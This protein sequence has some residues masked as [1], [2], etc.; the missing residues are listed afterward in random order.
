MDIRELDHVMH[1]EL[2]KIETPRS[3][4]TDFDFSFENI[5]SQNV[6]TESSRTRRDDATAHYP[7]PVKPLPAHIIETGAEEV[8]KM[9]YFGQGVVVGVIST[10]VNPT[11]PAI[12]ANYLGDQED[13]SQNHDFAWFEPYD[14][15]IVVPSDNS[16][17][18]THS[19]STK[20]K[21][22]SLPNN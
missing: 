10:G 16:G 21:A 14:T 4:A 2:D 5:S 19:K 22:M 12:K 8:W 9:G 13:G 11:H 6:S 17:L 3:Q 18:G 1:L 20:S 7:D 15:S